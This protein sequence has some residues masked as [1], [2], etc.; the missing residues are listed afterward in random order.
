MWKMRTY[1]RPYLA[2]I[3]VVML[4]VFLEVMATLRLPDLMSTIVDEGI[5]KGNIPLIWRTGAV[6]LAVALGGVACAVLGNFLASRASTRFGRDLRYD[7]FRKVGQYSPRDFI[8]FGTA[9]LITRTTNDVQQVQQVFHMSMRMAMRAP[10]MAIGGVLMVVRKDSKLALILLGLIP[11]I[12][13]IIGFVIKKG[14][15]LFKS[16]Q[17]KLDRLNLVLREQLMGVRVIRAFERR[18]HEQAR[19]DEANRDLTETSLTVNRMM[20]TL[21]PL[22]GLLVNAT[23]IAIIWFAAR[24][25]DLGAMQVGDL[26]A[27]LQYTMQIF[28]AVMM[29]S[30][31]FVMLPRASASAQRIVEVLDTQVSITDPEKPQ[32]IE[33]SLGVVRFEDV[34]FR[35][36]GAAASVL[37]NISFT[38]E[39]GQTTAIIGG[40][41][42]GK[43]T[44]LDLIP[45]FHDPEG[46]RITLDGV[47]IRDLTQRDL[48]SRLGYVPQQ[49]MLFSGTVASNI[50]GGK[51]DATDEEIKEA[52]RIAQATEFIEER[53][54]GYESYIAQSGTKVSGGQKQRLSIARALVRKPQVYLLDDTFSA[55]DYKTDARLRQELAKSA[56]QA[57]IIVVAQRV[58]TILHAEQII[59][60]DEG[61]I[62]GKGTHKS[63]LESCS[64]YQE[65]VASQFGEEAVS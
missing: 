42:S 8:N 32:R 46:G 55:L 36:A 24:R 52:A 29:L 45:R 18:A 40:T 48:R 1:F 11:V 28:M 63:L 9:S 14:I 26:M 27:F 30:F 12:A 23:N 16:L 49:A 13:I 33:S 57:T 50:R 37:S 53:E 44:I 62:V 21:M 3:I 54:D 65:I 6:M 31:I 7:I 41:G 15:P 35:Y 51:E 47:D 4:L 5:A 2:I 20:V 56:D 61:R 22:L 60:L 39:P 59:V 64:V 25:I 10:L 19:F 43:S 38:A 17:K 34:T 58:S